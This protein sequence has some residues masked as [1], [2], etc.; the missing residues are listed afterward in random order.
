MDG[1]RATKVYDDLHEA[2][3]RKAADGIAGSRVVF[4]QTNPKF[5]NYCDAR[6]ICQQAE[7]FVVAGILKL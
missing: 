4:R 7:A 3:A 5:C 1:S 2:N 6:Q